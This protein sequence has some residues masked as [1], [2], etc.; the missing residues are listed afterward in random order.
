VHGVARKG[1][2]LSRDISKVDR[3]RLV[4]A[5]WLLPI[6]RG[7]YMLC[8][9]MVDGEST[10]WYASFWDFVSFYLTER[11]GE[12]YCLAPDSSIDIHL[13]KTVIPRQLLVITK[14]GGSS[15]I[16]L[17]FETSLMMYQDEKA[18]PSE[19]ILGDA[20]R[21]TSPYVGRIN[22]LWQTMRK[23]IM[24]IFPAATGIP[25]DQKK[26]FEV[27]ESIAHEDAYHSLSI[28]GY[29]VSEALLSKIEKGEWDPE[30]NKEDGGQRDAMA[31]KGYLEAFKLVQTSIADIFGGKN[32]GK[33]F[34]RDLQSWF[35]A[36]FSGSVTAKIIEAERL[37]GYRNEQ[38]YIHPYMDGNGRTG[39]FLMT[40]ML[41]SGGF[42]WTIIHVEHRD[43]YFAALET[44][45]VKGDIVP[46]TQF[47]LSQMRK[48][49]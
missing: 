35:S 7:W 36:L 39:R 43:T 12:N 14:T 42:P 49:G 29:R 40:P 32:P 1:I 27:N 25:E 16:D 23:D 33:V 11:F 46:L 34:R 19:P 15:Q 44:A 37:M 26:Y 5:K 4:K 31:A 8:Q 2:V 10:A 13:G 30:N 9:P 45:S 21:I 47:I 17:P 38:V 48:K 3:E 20:N 24:N 6:I 28:E 18:L 22:V 41:A